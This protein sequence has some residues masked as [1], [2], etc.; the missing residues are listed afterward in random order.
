MDRNQNKILPKYKLIALLKA[1][2]FA[3]QH[4]IHKE[5]PP[6]RPSCHL[7]TD[8]TYTQDMPPISKMFLTS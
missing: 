7:Q 6:R 8:K 2:R 4:M 5:R 3:P 1:R